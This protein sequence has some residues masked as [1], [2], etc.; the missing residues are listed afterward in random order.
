VLWQP[1]QIQKL[2]SVTKPLSAFLCA[3]APL[4]EFSFHAKAQRR[5]KSFEWL[6]R[7][8]EVSS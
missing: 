2:R 1:A 6:N 5:T 7:G 3:F 8:F 4:R